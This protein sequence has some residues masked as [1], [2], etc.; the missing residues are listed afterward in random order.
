MRPSQ[1]RLLLTLGFMTLQG[2]T[3]AAAF[4]QI[5]AEASSPAADPARA[6]SLI[7]T[8]E[9]QK[10]LADRDA[11]QA[12]VTELEVRQGAYGEELAEAYVG[13]G[14]TL[15]A[16]DQDEAAAEALGKALQALRIGY[17]LNDVRQLP[18]LHALRNTNERLAR[19]EEVNSATH[20]IFT[21]AKHSP[22]TDEQLR[23][24]ALLDLGQWLRK[25]DAEN[26][27]PNFEANTKQVSELYGFEIARLEA[28]PSYAGRNVHLASLY[29][30]LA[31]TELGEAK[32][33]YEMP[34]SEFQ[35]PAAGEQRTVV[36]QQCFTATDRNGRPMQ[37]CN[38]PL[39]VPN[40][41]YY[42]APN[43]QKNSEIRE[44]LVLDFNQVLAAFRTLQDEPAPG[45]Q[46]ET[47]LTEVRRLTDEYNEFIKGVRNDVT[48]RVK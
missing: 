4:A 46:Q 21:I 9:R 38:Q 15:R 11:Y 43:A 42:L 24:A 27:L 33:K 40:L 18:I 41:N 5:L 19:W 22:A 12:R 14:A 29:L 17:G 16:L 3:G 47:L 39:E 34:I 44:H 1:S 26:L 23:I 30:D 37:A 2:I 28:L 31:T 32:R 13:L 6:Q 7:D 36:T 25:A 45:A 48:T 35:T 10:A 20:L 8:E